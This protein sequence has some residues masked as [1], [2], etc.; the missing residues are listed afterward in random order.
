MRNLLLHNLAHPS[1][2][3]CS[4]LRVE[5]SGVFA[6]GRAQPKLAVSV[7]CPTV[8]LIADPGFAAELAEQ[9]ADSLPNELADRVDSP[10][11]CN[12]SVRV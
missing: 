9:I 8:L 1:L 3:N 11:L 7:G 12:I 4:R 10:F 5:S 2:H 6:K